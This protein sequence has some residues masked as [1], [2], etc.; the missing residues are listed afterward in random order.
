MQALAAS[1][2]ANIEIEAWDWRYYAEKQRKAEHDLDEAELKPYFQLEAMIQ[3]SFDCATRLFGLE[4]REMTDAPRQHPDARTWEVTK[5]GR[6]MA[7]FIGD[8]FARGS[9][10]SGAWMSAYRGQSKLGGET[11]PI[12]TNTMNFAKGADGEATLLTF[13]DARTLF[14]EFGHGLHG[15]LSDVTYERVSGTSVPRDFVELPS[16]LFEHWLEVPE[17][18]AEFATHA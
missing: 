4:F 10:R 18:L 5:D 16:Q 9:K 15:M 2:G 17:V 11:R 6:H 12:I 7:V 13:D 14:H 8:Y 3:A 1:E